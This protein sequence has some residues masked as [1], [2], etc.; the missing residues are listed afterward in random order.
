MVMINTSARILSDWKNNSYRQVD[1]VFK[2]GEQFDNVYL[3]S[4]WSLINYYYWSLN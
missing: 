3:G 1:L 2:T 4:A